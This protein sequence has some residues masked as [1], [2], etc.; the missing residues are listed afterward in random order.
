MPK[1]LLNRT[2]DISFIAIS[3]WWVTIFARNINNTENYLFNLAYALLV[4]LGG[5]IAIINSKEWGSFTSLYGKALIG[6]GLSLIAWAIGGIIWAYYNFGGFTPDKFIT[7]TPI[8]D[9]PY[10]GL[11]DIG[12]G[13]FFPFCLFALICML[14]AVGFKYVWQKVY[15]KLLFTL[16]PLAATLITFLVYQN[17]RALAVTED[18]AV[19]GVVMNYYYNV[20]DA[21]MA[22]I[23]ISLLILSSKLS[24]GKL[25]G[26]VLLL[27]IGLIVQYLADFFFNLRVAQGTYFN[28]DFTDMLYAGALYLISVGCSM[29]TL[30]GRK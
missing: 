17:I 21:F 3:I 10:P 11:P 26:A 7:P 27:A 19:L 15:G 22:G 23:S 24:G 2:L 4:L 5:I 1:R 9:V 6:F 29:F 16:L 8:S 30:K 25:R 28:A 18:L 20:S 14:R 12:F 13:L